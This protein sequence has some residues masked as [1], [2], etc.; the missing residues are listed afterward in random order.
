MPR[1]SAA[2]M[3]AAWSGSAQS[4]E[5]LIR[6]GAEVNAQT[7]LGPMPKF[8]EPGAG[9]VGAAGDGALLV[10][11]LAQFVDR[12]ADEEAALPPHLHARACGQRLQSRGIEARPFPLSTDPW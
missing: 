2:L 9:R 12:G 10:R 7:R 8:V 5:L 6:A 3:L 4:V 1:E 11:F